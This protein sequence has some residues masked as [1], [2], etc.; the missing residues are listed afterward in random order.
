MSETRYLLPTT[1]VVP[2][3]GTVVPVVNKNLLVVG[4]H[5]TRY[6]LPTTGVVPVNGTVVPVVNKNLLAVG[7][8]ET[9]YLLPTTGVV[10]LCSPVVAAVPFLAALH[11]ELL[12]TDGVRDAAS[13]TPQQLAL[14]GVGVTLSFVAVGLKTQPS[15]CRYEHHYTRCYYTVTDLHVIMSIM[16]NH[17]CFYFNQCI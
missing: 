13:V 6:L 11:V 1:G 4:V 12:E 17:V 15:H 9:R 5:E 14:V 10:P 16:N 2:L 7:V 8:S 3:N